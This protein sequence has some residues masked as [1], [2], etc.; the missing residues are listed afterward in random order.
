MRIVG[1]E[2]ANAMFSGGIHL[3]SAGSSDFIQNYYINPVLNRAYSADQFSNILM[4]SFSTFVQVNSTSSAS[5]LDSNGINTHKAMF[6][7]DF[8]VVIGVLA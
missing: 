8:E 5:P 7:T 2:R 6:D 3:L 4:R 1:K